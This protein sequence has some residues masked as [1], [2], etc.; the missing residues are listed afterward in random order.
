MNKNIYIKYGIILGVVAIVSL[1]VA[2]LLFSNNKSDTDYIKT[3]SKDIEISDTTITNPYYDYS[4]FD[5]SNTFYTYEDDSYT[6]A[7]GIDVSEHNLDIDF[8]KVK[9]A[10]IEFVYIRIGWRGYTEG[11][12]YL[13]NKY[14]EYIKDAKEAGLKVGVY[15]FSQA[16]NKQEAIE[17]ARWVKDTLGD[18]TL[19]LPVVYDFENITEGE[20]RTD[21]LTKEEVTDNA[22]YFCSLLKSSYGAMIYGNKYILNTYYY[23]DKMSNYDI[24]FAQYHDEPETDI[25]FNIWQYTE[26]AKI[27][28]IEK[29]TDLNIMLIEKTTNK[30]N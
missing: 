21:G 28:G 15:F 27:D 2:L 12:I 18:T 26:S 19:D 30:S 6:S 7:I 16:I 20:A 25:K 22:I 17:E 11:G 3:Q 4:K 29:E 14:E 8:N 23:L 24:W 1:I 10:G 9:E 5:M 13:D